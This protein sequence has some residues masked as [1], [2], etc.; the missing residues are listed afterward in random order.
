MRVK[1]SVKFGNKESAFKFA[2]KVNGKVNDLS[3][4]PKAKSKYSVTYDRVERPSKGRIYKGDN[5][6]SYPN[7]FWK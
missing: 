5:D 2:E 6:F 4:D 3:K 7:E 1:E